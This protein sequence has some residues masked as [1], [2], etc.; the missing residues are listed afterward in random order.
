MQLGMTD[1]VRSN[2]HAE[3][4]DFP[5]FAPGHEL[6]IDKAFYPCSHEAGYNEHGGSKP[7]RL[8]NRHC[9]G[10]EVAE[11]IVKSDN[12]G[13]GSDI[14]RLQRLHCAIKSYRSI[15]GITKIAHLTSKGIGRCI[16]F[17]IRVT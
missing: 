12:H 8:Q 1:C 3:G 17:E 9:A 13:S 5:H 4:L 7:M 14:G 15:S 10:I 6:S 11:A 16:C 2:L